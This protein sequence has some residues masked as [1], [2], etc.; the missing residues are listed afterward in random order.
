MTT[1]PLAPSRALTLPLVQATR[2]LRGSSWLS[3]TSSTLSDSS[4]VSPS[5]RAPLRFDGLQPLHHIV[6]AASKVV[7]QEHVFGE[8]SVIDQLVGFNG[9]VAFRAQPGHPGACGDDRVR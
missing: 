5:G 6:G 9:M 8:Q 3:A 1:S 2:L 7:M 4:I